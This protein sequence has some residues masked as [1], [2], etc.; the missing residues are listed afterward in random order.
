MG[1]VMAMQHYSELEE[2]AG[3][4]LEDS[5][6]LDVV[7]RP[8]LLRLEADLVLREIHPFFRAPLVNE[9]YCYR[10]GVLVFTG[11]TRLEWD[12]QGLTPAHDST[13]QIDY[14]SIDVMS[15]VNSKYRIEGDFGVLEVT[16]QGLSV[17]W[18]PV[19]TGRGDASV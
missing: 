5:W 15:F 10:R 3:L 6:V 12:G 4:Y 17:E 1:L 19:S 16:A 7:A 9:Q 13:G 2:L 11:V 18:R 8:G 14:G